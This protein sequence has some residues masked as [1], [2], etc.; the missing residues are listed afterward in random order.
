LLLVLALAA[1]KGPGDGTGGGGGRDEGEPRRITVFAAASL[2]DALT[3]ANERFR[4]QT[5]VE[6]LA[7]FAG[8]N[9]LAQQIIAAGKADVFISADESWMNRV[10]TAGRIA[11]GTRAELLSNSLVVVANHA[12]PLQIH[13]PQDLCTVA[14]RYMSIGNPEA[15]PEG[16]Y[17]RRWMQ[18]VD[19]AGT[20]L[21]DRVKDRVAPAM[22]APSALGQVESNEQAVGVLYRTD[23]VKSQRIKPLFDVTGSGAPHIVYIGATV[24]ERPNPK[25]ALEYLTFLQGET[26]GAVFM[27][28]GFLRP[29]PPGAPVASQ[30]TSTAP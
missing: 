16:R 25:I 14:F 24:K 22:D 21:W 19:C 5:G 27:R 8:S 1:C 4:K 9:V 3:A 20:T 17:A 15:V 18:S 12:F 10:D 7:N 28:A 30:P 29:E 26:A 13:Q 23:A 6:V 2:R 11:P